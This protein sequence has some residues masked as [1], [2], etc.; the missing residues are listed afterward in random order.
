METPQKLINIKSKKQAKQTCQAVFLGFQHVPQERL[1]HVLV[2][3][4]ANQ[5]LW[6]GTKRRRAGDFGWPSVWP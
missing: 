2:H 4:V 6:Q 3:E 1:Q 5:G